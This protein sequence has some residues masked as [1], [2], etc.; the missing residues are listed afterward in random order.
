MKKIII[1]MLCIS[2]LCGSLTVYAA[3]GTDVDVDIANSIGLLKALD[4][5]TD[6][7]EFEI[8]GNIKKDVFEDMAARVFKIQEYPITSDSSENTMTVMDA[9][10]ILNNY[11]GYR[12]YVKYNGGYPLGD[13]VAAQKNGLLDNIDKCDVPLSSKHAIILLRNALSARIITGFAY[14]G[15]STHKILDDDVLYTYYGIRT[16]TGVVEAN[17]ITNLMGGTPVKDDALMIDGKM[18]SYTGDEDFLGQEVDF[19]FDD[20][21]KIIHINANP[22]TV[23]TEVTDA[24]EPSFFNWKYQYR[25][26]NGKQRKIKLTN[27]TA[28]VH[29]HELV[30]RYN[31]DILVPQD[32]Y[33]R[34]VDNGGDGKIDFVSIISYVNYLV[35]EVNT[36]GNSDGVIIYENLS[37]NN[38]PAVIE[39]SKSNGTAIVKTAEGKGFN[40][41]NIARGDIV[42]VIGT[43]SNK[44]LYAKEVIVSRE[45]VFG[46]LESKTF[47]G[48]TNKLKINGEI[49]D[50]S[51]NYNSSASGL[52]VYTKVDF[53]LDYR[54]KIAGNSSVTNLGHSLSFGY[55]IKAT[56]DTQSFDKKVLFKILR[57]NGK[58][59]IYESAEKVVFDGTTYKS[60]PDKV[61]SRLMK[62]GTVTPQLICYGVDND[63]MIRAIDTADASTGAD[64]NDSLKLLHS[65]MPSNLYHISKAKSFG[66]KINYTQNTVFF[67][68]PQNVKS[69]EDWKFFVLP[70]NKL[71][72]ADFKVAGYSINS[73][74]AADAI[75]LYDMVPTGSKGISVVKEITNVLNSKGDIT[76]CITLETPDKEVSLIAASSDVVTKAKSFNYSD[77]AYYSLEVGDAIRYNLNID[78]E[79]MNIRIV[80]D[81]SEGTVNG[82]K[83]FGQDYQE[84]L[85]IIDAAA[86]NIADNIIQVAPYGSESN[87]DLTMADMEN[88]LLSNFTIIVYDRNSRNKIF[89]GTVSDIKTYLNNNS[90]CS[91][92]VV[93]TA[94]GVGELLYVIND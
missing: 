73:G 57:E 82:G 84:N 76:K 62:N 56:L 38:I 46:T 13:I 60:E 66:G 88:H 52:R 58:I 69:A 86:Y 41:A 53:L 43:V 47:D 75:V 79:V 65:S 44:M 50:V 11:L 23:I 20:D 71:Y 94:V 36:L 70:Q 4:I 63:G 83:A 8:E 3:E 67:C 33:V 51:Q 80:Y 92:V 26:N 5:I 39:P 30:S 29:N 90:N 61:I 64:R 10:V 34:F 54:N 55:L 6:D 49:Y 87:P 85:R 72:A 12:D 35:S 42:S 91:R 32:G 21:N 40:P 93:Q 17:S 25:D 48:K 9:V 24:M 59:E 7:T 81:K 45:T 74:A 27:K 19:Y 14:K 68:V 22:N 37:G 18:Y 28:I 89:K 31:E 2:L 78:G 16:E 77:S 1:L 15:W